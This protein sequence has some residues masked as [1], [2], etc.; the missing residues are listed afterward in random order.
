MHRNLKGCPQALKW[1]AYV[2]LVRSLMEYSS[3]IWNPT[4]KKDKEALE[5]VQR[6]AAHW[7][8]S[9]YR[10]RST[11]TAM[12]TDLGLV[13][14]ENRED[15]KLLLM[16]KVV[17]ILVSVTWEELG[18]EKADK[19]TRASHS[20]KLHHHQ[21]T[22]IE[23]RHSFICSTILEWNKLPASMAEADSVATFKSQLMRLVDRARAP[24]GVILHLEPC[25][26]SI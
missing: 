22:T 5:K 4:L 14:L 8:R 13:T 23:Y 11:V 9:D 10:Q 6:R 7:I 2:S 19:C 16:Y 21:P 18:L 17:H 24:I 20:H 1:A 15:Q 26:L 3:T 25:Q 12:L